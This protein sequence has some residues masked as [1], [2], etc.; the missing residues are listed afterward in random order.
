LVQA[1]ELRLSVAHSRGN[2]LHGELR[3][4][5]R[6]GGVESGVYGGE[7]P[8]PLKIEPWLAAIKAGRTF[9]TNG[10]LL[11]FSLG[12]QGIGGEVQ[13]AGNND[14]KQEVPFSAKLLRSFRLIIFRLS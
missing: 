8:G 2:G 11:R 3:V 13:L 9:A 12:G 14:K 1:A 6:A 4:V 10:P 7:A 5:A